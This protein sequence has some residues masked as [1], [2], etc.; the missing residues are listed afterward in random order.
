MAALAKKMD[1]T[2]L[3]VKQTLNVGGRESIS[4]VQGMNALFKAAFDPKTGSS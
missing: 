3:T 2:E 4:D 1:S